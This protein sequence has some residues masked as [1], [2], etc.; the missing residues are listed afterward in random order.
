MEVQNVGWNLSLN[1]M[2]L[3]SSDGTVQ[4]TYATGGKVTDFVT[5][6]PSNIFP[7]KMVE[8]STSK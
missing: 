7:W 8:I 1:K 5:D 4:W 6:T 3:L 2:E